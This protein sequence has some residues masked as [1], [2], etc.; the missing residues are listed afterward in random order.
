MS[1]GTTSIATRAKPGKYLTF[2][3]GEE[4][5]GVEILRVREIIC[6]TTITAVPRTPAFVKGV[7]NLRGKIVPVFDLRLK[8]EMSPRT[9]TRETCIIIVDINFNSSRICLGV[10][11]DAVSEVL[12]ISAAEIE[13]VPSFG[14][15][16]NTSFLLGMARTKSTVKLLLDIEKVLDHEEICALESIK[17]AIDST[18]LRSEN[19]MAAQDTK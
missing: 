11:V 18:V 2:T 9:Y 10:V 8:F 17:P 5:Y 15:Q 4:S 1:S 19:H 16:I 12:D 13:G 7:I 14:Q 6:I 3:L